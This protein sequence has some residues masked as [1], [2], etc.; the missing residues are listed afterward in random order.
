[1]LHPCLQ[2]ITTEHQQH[3][4]NRH[5]PKSP[6]ASSLSTTRLLAVLLSLTGSLPMLHN[7][8]LVAFMLW[9]PFGHMYRATPFVLLFPLSA[10]I[11]LVNI[12]H[13]QSHAL[14]CLF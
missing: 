5:Y 8:W 10:S 14:V 6:A 9:L 2:F 4:P 3:L 12:I 7:F 1:M 11:Y 13:C